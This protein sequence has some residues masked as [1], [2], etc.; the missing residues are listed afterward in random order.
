MRDMSNS[1]YIDGGLSAHDLR[2]VRGECIDVL[3]VLRSKF[4]GLLVE[5]FDFFLGQSGYVLH[6]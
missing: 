3:I 5:F 2:C 6:Q 4:I 1:A